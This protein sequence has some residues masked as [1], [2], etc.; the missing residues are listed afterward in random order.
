MY[1]DDIVGILG[2]VFSAL[3]ATIGFIWSV[4]ILQAIFPYL[5]GAFT[6]YFVQHRLQMGSE[7]RERK[8]ENYDLMR[9]KVYGPIF[10]QIGKILEAC[11]KPF[12][13]SFSPGVE[14]LKEAMKDYFFSTIKQDLKS[15]LSEL[16]ER[17]ETYQNV[18]FAAEIFYCDITRDVI[19][20][21]PFG[22]DLGR[23]ANPIL[24]LRIG[25]TMASN[26][27]LKEAVFLK[28]AP[29]DF[30]TREKEKYGE[31][32]LIEVTIGSRQNNS[33]NDFES[34]Y[35]LVMRKMEKEPLCV[36]EREQRFRLEQELGSL[37]DQLEGFVNPQS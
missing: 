3:F 5:A 37:L 19:M 22:V 17:I 14:N 30:V 31:N 21:P 34:L 27:S 9:D 13:E 7:K 16:V 32:V 33:L 2:A 36:E 24:T 29:K 20:K 4:G 15:K 26:I 23:D 35:A 28:L 6:T 18:R 1:R 25:K 8:R 12:R 10:M 11:K